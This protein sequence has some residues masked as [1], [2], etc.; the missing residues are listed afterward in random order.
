[1]GLSDTSSFSSTE[2]KVVISGTG[3]DIDREGGTGAGVGGGDR[4]LTG[5]MGGCRGLEY[6]ESGKGRV[7]Q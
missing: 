1:M 5:I 4:G 6:G 3:I 7:L 2:L